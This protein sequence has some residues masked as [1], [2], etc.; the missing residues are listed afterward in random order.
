MV[1][2]SSG[3]IKLF[4]VAGIQV[5]LH[6]SWLLM[7]LYQM[8]RPHV[9]ESGMWKVAEYLMLFVIVLLH[10]FGHAFATRQVGGESR[11]ILLWPFGGIAFVKV[12]PRPGAELWS[13]A[14]GPLVNVLFFPVFLGALWLASG[15]GLADRSP[16]FARFLQMMFLINWWVLKF[17]V[18]PIYP[19]DGGQILRS[20][21]WF[22]FGRARSLQIACVIGF[23][24]LPLIAWWGMT[25]GQP[26]YAIFMAYF[27]GQQCYAG[28][29]HAKVIA[30]L[31]RMPRH[32]DFACPACKQS[33]PEAR[34]WACANCRQA[35]D[36]FATRATC[37]HCATVQPTTPCAYCT[38]QHPIDE[39]DK[40][41]RPTG[42]PPII[43]I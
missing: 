23:I 15:S 41:R 22:V 1:N 10:E 12:P 3:S 33:P 27:L 28:F 25:H 31:D 29:Q 40:V 13:I 19:L 4:R 17:N 26:I 34:L 8:S 37:P 11:E 6:W 5:Y 32:P 9:Y 21:L 39:W 14:A 20:L 38:A 2:A 16:D 42:A 24:G 7:A 43:D 30:A 18:L 36:P 35:F